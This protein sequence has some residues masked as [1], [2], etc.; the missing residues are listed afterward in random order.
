MALLSITDTARELDLAFYRRLEAGD[1]LYFPQTPTQ[2]CDDDARFLLTRRQS[3]AAYHKNIAYRPATGVLTGVAGGDRDRLRRLIRSFSEQTVSLLRTLMPRYAVS[4]HIDFTSFRPFEEAGR[5]LSLHSRNDLLH[6]DAFPTRPTHG[7]RIMRFFTNLNP[8]Q[9]R[10]WIT[11][12]PFDILAGQL[13]TAGGVVDLAR[14]STSPVRRWLAAAAGTMGLRKFSASPYDKVMHHFHNFMKENS[15]FQESCRKDRWEFPPRSSWIVFTDS[16]SHAVLS[17]QFALEQ[18]FIISR[19]SMVAP[20]R[21]PINVLE[22]LTGM[23][24]V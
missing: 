12:D 18:T 16:V 14:R 17:G 10:I 11:T 2:F 13:A 23:R 9:S 21:A 5:P 24:L 6:V 20:E 7:D 19:A 8:T 4:W 15:P 1:I 22:Q 3:G